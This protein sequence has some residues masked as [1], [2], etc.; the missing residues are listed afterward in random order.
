MQWQ[1]HD[2]VQLRSDVTYSRLQTKYTQM[3]VYLKRTYGC[4]KFMMCVVLF[5]LGITFGQFGKFQKAT[6]TGRSII[7]FTA[8]CWTIYLHVTSCGCFYSSD[9]S[10]WKKENITQLAFCRESRL[11]FKNNNNILRQTFFLPVAVMMVCVWHL[12]WP[13]HSAHK[14][15]CPSLALPSGLQTHSSRIQNCDR[16]HEAV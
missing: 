16:G 9:N 1:K 11:S 4:G 6:F 10:N 2:P 5:C 14:L 7:I 12:F 13:F 8:Y 15:A 3:Q